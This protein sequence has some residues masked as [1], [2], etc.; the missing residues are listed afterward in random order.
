M[1][2][3]LLNGASMQFS[4]KPKYV[5]APEK[6]EDEEEPNIAAEKTQA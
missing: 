2:Y 4:G 6:T 1:W 5:L 3:I